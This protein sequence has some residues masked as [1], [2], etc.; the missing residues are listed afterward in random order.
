MTKL[1]N[2][3]TVKMGSESILHKRS[4]K[5]YNLESYLNTDQVIY[6]DVQFTKNNISSKTAV[7]Q[8][9]S[10]PSVSGYTCVAVS[11][12]SVSGGNSG[13]CLVSCAISG[14]NTVWNGAGS[15]ASPTIKLRYVYIKNN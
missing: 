6:R 14:D 2:L 12:L 10:V 9:T 4:N 13:Y 1:Y 3:N 15:S 5:Y 11:V 7:Y 8:E